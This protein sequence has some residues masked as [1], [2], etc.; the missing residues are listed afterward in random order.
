MELSERVA[1]VTGGSRGIGEAI[2]RLLVSKGAT[3]II[4]DVDY[5]A[6][7]VWHRRFKSQEAVPW[8]LK[9]T[10]SLLPVVKPWYRRF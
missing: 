9:L 8:L 1:I 10:S 2:V 5:A 3:A 4:A 6:A 7:Q